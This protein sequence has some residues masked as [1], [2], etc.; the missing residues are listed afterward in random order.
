MGHGELSGP[1]P[2][3]RGRD[4]PTRVASSFA[5]RIEALESVGTAFIVPQHPHRS[6]CPR[7]HT[8]EDS[9]WP[10]EAP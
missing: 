1:H 9:H 10:V 4:D 5:D 3:D 7:F 6:A 8:N 2:I